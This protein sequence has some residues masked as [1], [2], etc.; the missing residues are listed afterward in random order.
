MGVTKPNKGLSVGKP[1]EGRWR[2]VRR[3]GGTRVL[4]SPDG[5]E[6]LGTP[7]EVARCA[8]TPERR[9]SLAESLRV[10][11]FVTYPGTEERR[12]I[13]ALRR[14]E[15]ILETE[16]DAK[17]GLGG[18][19]SL[20]PALAIRARAAARFEG[21]GLGEWLAQAADELVCAAADANGGVLPL[22]I[23]R[24]HV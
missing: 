1:A 11:R 23:G 21:V 14:R 16:A 18:G 17:L 15:A 3:K 12:R 13:A 24:A 2:T 7:A 4:I 6:F 5:R 19:V 22:K 9:R 8:A 20:P 10:A